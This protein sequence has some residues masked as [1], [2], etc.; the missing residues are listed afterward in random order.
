MNESP[1][2]PFSAVATAR[3]LVANAGTAALATMSARGGGPFASLVTV[4][5]DRTGS[6]ILLLSKL[7]VHTANIAAD[8]RASLMFADDGAPDPDA[9]P[10]VR[11]RVTLT[12]RIDQDDARHTRER[13][14]ERHPEA[15]HYA[16]FSDFAFYRMTVET[17]H[18]VAG[19]G[20]IVDIPAERLIVAP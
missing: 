6:P 8:N 13:F 3:A 5:A 16:D 18:L 1:R 12:G 15:E 2:K 7:A 14:L 10:L 20:R 11:S 4:A 17:A 19:F 9:D